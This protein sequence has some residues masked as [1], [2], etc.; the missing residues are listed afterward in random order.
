MVSLVGEKE[1]GKDQMDG[2][3]FS[4]RCSH[5]DL[6]ESFAIQKTTTIENNKDR[7]K[8]NSNQT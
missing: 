3:L 8:A 1:I 6:A 2:W 4:E 7:R 5:V